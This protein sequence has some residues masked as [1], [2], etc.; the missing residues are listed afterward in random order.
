MRFADVDTI[1]FSNKYK[2]SIESLV[3]KNANGNIGSYAFSNLTKM[4]TVDL[5][6]GINE[7][8]NDEFDLY[9][10]NSK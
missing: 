6:E 3:I 2:N 7:I 8:K 1:H 5:C 10:V 9:I 4:K